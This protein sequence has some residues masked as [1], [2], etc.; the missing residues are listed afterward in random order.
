MRLLFC[1]L[2]CFVFSSLS[3]RVI[4]LKR[5]FSNEQTF[6]KLQMP[7]L[8]SYH[9]EAIEDTF[10]CVVGTSTNCSS[11]GVCVEP[12][13]CQCNNRYTTFNSDYMQCNYHQKN[14]V[15][16]FC[17]EFFFGAFGAG[18]WYLRNMGL[19]IG[20]LM[21]CVGIALID[22]TLKHCA[23]PEKIRK[24]VKSMLGLGLVIWIIIELVWIAQAKRTDG[25]GASIPHL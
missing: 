22:F 9:L 6:E 8:A 21:F 16:A 19:A 13:Q 25:N 1:L 3:V 20:Q 7:E 17:L 12:G 4:N 5:E 14:T 23:V 10:T 18:H 24:H 15:T 2:V 11:N